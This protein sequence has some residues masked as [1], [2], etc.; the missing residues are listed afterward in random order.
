MIGSRRSSGT[1]DRVGVALAAR[2]GRDLVHGARAVQRDERD[3]VVELR[4][5][6]LPQGALHALG[7]ELEHAD[8]VAA[9]PS[10]RRSSRRRAAAVDMSGRSPVERSMMSSASSM[11]SRLRRPRKSIFSRPSSSTGFIENCVTSL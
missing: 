7:L 2:V 10:S 4:R 11:T 5:L 3:E 8:R 6:D 9:R 1:V